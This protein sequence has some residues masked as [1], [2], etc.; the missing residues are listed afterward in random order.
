MSWEVPGS[1]FSHSSTTLK[2][3]ITGRDFDVFLLDGRRSKL[4][5]VSCPG[6]GA[7]DTGAGKNMEH[8]NN[9]GIGYCYAELGSPLALHLQFVMHPN[10]SS[11]HRSNTISVKTTENML[12][13]WAIVDELKCDAQASAASTS[14]ACVSNNSLCSEGQGLFPSYTCYCAAGYSGNPYVAAGCSRDDQEWYNPDHARREKCERSC[15]NIS[16]PFPF[17]LEEGCAASRGFQLNC[18]DP[19]SLILLFDSGS[20][21][22]VSHIDINE[23]V[24]TLTEPTSAIMS[25]GQS[26]FYGS[27]TNSKSF[28]WV[29]DGLSCKDAMN[30]STYACVSVHSDCYGVNSG[31]DDAGYTSVGYRCR[32]KPGFDG[33]PYIPGGCHRSRHFHTLLLGVF[34]GLGLTLGFIFIAVSIAYCVRRWRKDVEKKLRNK[35]FRENQ[36]LLLEQLIASDEN[37]TSDKTKIF[38]LE[39]LEKAT[40]NF[41]NTRI[42]GRG[43]HGMVYKGILADQRVVAIKRPKVIEPTKIKEFINEVAI[44]SQ[45]NHRNIVKLFGCCL[46]TK[47][48]SLVYDFV[49]NGSL[50]KVLHSGPDSNF[51]LSWDDCIRIATE[52]AGALCYLHSS[53]SISV[54]HRDVKSDNI[55]LDANYTAKVSDFGASRL[56]P[57][58]GTHIVTVVQG[59]V[60][61]LDPEYHLTGQLN[62][63]SD[64]YS[65][66]VVL[67]ELL[68]RRKPVFR[69]DSG[70]TLGLSMY[71][72]QELKSRPIIEIVSAEL[73]EEAT[74]E[75]IDSFSSLA[76]MCLRPRGEERPTMKQVE[77]TLQTMRMKRLKSCQVVPGNGQEIHPSLRPRA[78]H[79][80][81]Q[82][83]ATYMSYNSEQPS[84]RCLS[85]EQEFISSAEMPR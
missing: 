27:F 40:N 45:I 42:V 13:D 29:I 51:A 19:T 74:M 71:F 2:L 26:L 79:R 63:K 85:L 9:D 24:V 73:R 20:H 70:S 6:E 58:D 15:G 39:E 80:T 52:T 53:A 32:C 43:G 3:N 7:I 57:I 1:S 35:Y 41:D 66:G 76:E 65:F 61:Y 22:S 84:Q 11:L 48:P 47:V 82:S 83:W 81:G 59:T 18:S 17:G 14:Y 49:P 10:R 34:M 33:N 50:S 36:G 4:C 25:T 78:K 44:L 67:L 62:E 28:N 64:V 54:F 46:E 68:L 31:D 56:V 37:A 8:C 5:T 75:E 77:M 21:G 60:G 55:L 38:S 16:V 30:S 72:R 23:G 12:L 69:S